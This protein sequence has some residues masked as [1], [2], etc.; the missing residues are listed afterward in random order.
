M[1]GSTRGGTAE[2]TSRDQNKRQEGGYRK[3]NER[4]KSNI[5]E[6]SW[7]ANGGGGAKQSG[8]FCDSAKGG[9]EHVHVDGELQLPRTT[10]GRW[11]WMGSTELDGR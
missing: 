11:R 5:G 6:K 10:Y 4:M 7:R 2:S 1:G 8:T 9:I 3:R